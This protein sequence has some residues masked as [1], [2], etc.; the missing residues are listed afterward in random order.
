GGIQDRAMAERARAE[1]HSAVE[2]RNDASIGEQSRD[3]GLDRVETTLPQTRVANS[4]AHLLLRVIGPEVDVLEPVGPQPS[5]H[6]ERAQRAAEGEPDV[7]HR[8]LDEDRA[9][10]ERLDELV[11]LDVAEHA[12]G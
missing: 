2:A 6:A 3:F 1:L 5:M 4:G 8:G 12:A 9:E 10:A 11:E 7:T